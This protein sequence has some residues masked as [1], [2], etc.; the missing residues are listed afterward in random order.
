MSYQKN[1]IVLFWVAV[2]I[3]ASPLQSS[4]SSCSSKGIAYEDLLEDYYLR[5][6]EA[7]TTEAYFGNS[8]GDLLNETEEQSQEDLATPE[9]QTFTATAHQTNSFNSRNTN[10]TGLDLA[11][12]KFGA[13]THF[14]TVTSWLFAI[15]ALPKNR[16]GANCRLNSGFSSC[17]DRN[18]QWEEFEKILKSWLTMK[19]SGSLA[20]QSNWMLTDVGNTSPNF[21]FFDINAPINE[22]QPFAQKLIAPEN[23]VFYMRGDL[24]GDIFSLAAQLQRMLNEGIIDDSFKIINPHH[25]MIFLGDYVDRGAYGCEVIY[26]ILRLSLANPDN[27]IAVRGNHEEPLINCRDGFKDEVLAKFGDTTFLNFA[28]INRMYDFLPAVLY[29]GCEENQTKTNYAQCCHGGIEIGYNSMNFLSEK[30]RTYQLIDQLETKTGLETLASFIDNDIQKSRRNY[31]TDLDKVFENP[32]IVDKKP[33]SP[34]DLGFLWNDF[35]DTNT[36]QVEFNTN[37]GLGLIYGK[38][39]TIDALNLQDSINNKTLWVFRGHQHSC[40]NNSMMQGIIASKGIYKLW[41]PYET[42]PQR[43]IHDGLVWTL[44]VGADSVYG[45]HLQFSFDTYVSIRSAK[46]PEDWKMEV[47]NQEIINPQRQLLSQPTSP[48]SRAG[49]TTNFSFEDDPYYRRPQGLATPLPSNQL[50]RRKSSRRNLLDY[51]DDGYGT[52]R[53]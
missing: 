39:A 19:A 4:N 20:E 40:E 32:D 45:E 33:T 10:Q 48:L 3:I 13:S 37:R 15:Q 34:Q 38:E 51:D 31:N 7:T 30:F 17:G 22:F 43:S 42:T 25:W 29:I 50:R 35:D 9:Q 26:T 8:A 49:F 53:D 18:A 21:S 36:V 41:H 16:Q 2:I 27:V 24:H 28:K 52:E 1:I 46:K 23:S 47:F 11:I 44:N 12:S 6:P 5:D 14:P